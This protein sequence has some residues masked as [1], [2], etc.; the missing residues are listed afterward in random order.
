MSFINYTAFPAAMLLTIVSY[1]QSPSTIF[2]FV[3]SSAPLKKTKRVKF[4]GI[5]LLLILLFFTGHLRSQSLISTPDGKVITAGGVPVK[6]SQSNCGIITDADGNRYN[7]VVIGTQCW[8]QENLVTTKYNDGTPISYVTD[9]AAW[10]NLWVEGGYCWFNNDIS[11]RIPNGALYNFSAVKTGKLC[12][13]GWH[14]PEINQWAIMTN[15]LIANGYNF[16]GST[17]GNKIAK[18]MASTTGW[19]VFPYNRGTPGNT[20]YA[21]YRNKSGFTCFPGGYR[22]GISARF[23]DKGTYGIWWST[24]ING[25]GYVVCFE[26][27]HRD[28]SIDT[29]WTEPQNSGCSVRCLKD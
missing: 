26:M 7:T 24:Q 4:P 6:R 21:L 13:A 11:N 10:Y 20:D 8:M 29:N 17:S 27:E 22:A 9:G 3:N 14:V 5:C 19:S 15:Y 16:D 12:P 25:N 23:F 28:P 2:R 1:G 18:S